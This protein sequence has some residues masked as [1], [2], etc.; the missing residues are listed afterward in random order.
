M[1]RKARVPATARINKRKACALLLAGATRR[2]PSSV[3]R[4]RLAFHGAAHDG[5]DFH[6]FARWR[7]YGSDIAARENAQDE[8]P[9]TDYNVAHC[10][11][12]TGS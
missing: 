10:L 6:G 9:R 5:R 11:G 12:G 3:L 4:T 2:S 7:P 1:D 8:M